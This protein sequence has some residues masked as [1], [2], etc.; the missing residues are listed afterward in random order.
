MHNLPVIG[1]CPANEW[2]RT[3][4]TYQLKDKRKK[5]SMYCS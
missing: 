2:G 5:I 4:D 3:A 1:E